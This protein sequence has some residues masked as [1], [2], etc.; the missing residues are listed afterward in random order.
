MWVIV[1][2]P[3]TGKLFIKQECHMKQSETGNLAKYIDH[4]ILKPNVTNADIE[5]GC[6]EAIEYGFKAVC[7][8]PA[9]VEYAVSLLKGKKPFVVAVVGFPLGASQ[10][11]TKAFEAKEAIAAG[12]EEIDMVINIGALKEKNY[13]LVYQDIYSVVNE[14][15]PCVVKVIIETCYLERD[16]KI[17][18]SALA[19]VAGAKYVKTSTGFGEKGA[20]VEDIKLIKSVVDGKVKIKASGGIKTYEE[21]LKMIE[22]G[23]DRLGTSSSVNIV[24][25]K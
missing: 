11:A 4:S 9:F 21:A 15:K 10:T 14:A 20:T 16:E 19:V 1:G 3:I 22:A 17:I 25:G 6:K 23:A 7:V 2:A 5:K 18:A 12:A 8:N 24:M 13:Q